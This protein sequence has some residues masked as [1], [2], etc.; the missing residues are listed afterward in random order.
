MKKYMAIFFGALAVS[1]AIDI[2]EMDFQN[3][4][5]LEVLHI[6]T[7]VAALIAFIFIAVNWR[8]LE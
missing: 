6:I 4:G 7:T 1:H 8:R 5:F 3:L 2:T